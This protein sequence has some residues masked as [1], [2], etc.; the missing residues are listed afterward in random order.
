MNMSHD[1]VTE[2]EETLD[3]QVNYKIIVTDN[4]KVM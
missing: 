4:G 1:D 3:N 2:D